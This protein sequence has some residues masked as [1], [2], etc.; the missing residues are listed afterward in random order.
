MVEVNA[1]GDAEPTRFAISRGGVWVVP[2]GEPFHSLTSSACE[3][4]IRRCT[5]PSSPSLRSM[6]TGGYAVM[7]S[8]LFP[9]KEAVTHRSFSRSTLYHSNLQHYSR[10]GGE[11]VL[12]AVCVRPAVGIDVDVAQRQRPNI[13]SQ[14][15]Y[16]HRLQCHRTS[17]W[18]SLHRPAQRSRLRRIVPSNCWLPWRWFG[19]PSV[20]ATLQC[21]C[22]CAV[23]P[24]TR[25]FAFS[26]SVKGD[27][28]GLLTCLGVQGTIT[29]LPMKVV[30]RRP[31]FS[32]H[33]VARLW[34]WGSSGTV[35]RVLGSYERF[36][37]GWSG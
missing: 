27:V 19:P 11:R 16:H 3:W 10:L 30:R 25:D 29:R 20:C 34:R 8:A 5:I 23:V 26:S 22:V 1:V 6:P 4:G 7:P 33:R 21:S 31:G 2:R 18:Y 14:S 9:G 28:H 36:H 24:N 15:A 32:S 13:V 12:G 35:T 37:H 17:S